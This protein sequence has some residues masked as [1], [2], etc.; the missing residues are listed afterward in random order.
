MKDTQ[1][2]KTLVDLHKSSKYSTNTACNFKQVVSC[3][4]STS[5]WAEKS[6]FFLVLLDYWN[7]RC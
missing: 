2:L 4:Q 1:I 3:E 7:L 5:S 6:E